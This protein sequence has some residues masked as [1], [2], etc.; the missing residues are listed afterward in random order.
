MTEAQLLHQIQL[1]LGQDPRLR[2]FRNNVGQA[3]DQV[4]GQHVRFGLA[5]GASDLLGIV[6]PVGRWLAL[7]VK[8]PAGRVR[9][10]QLAF[11]AM[12]NEFGG[13]ARVVRSVEEAKA[14]LAEAM[15]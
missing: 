9:P 4:T 10:E 6:R 7:E 11:L 15:K 8:S 12:V 3:R 14:A 1:E 2:I 13:V 5:T